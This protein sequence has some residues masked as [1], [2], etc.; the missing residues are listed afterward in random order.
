[1]RTT[2]L[3]AALLAMAASSARAEEHSYVLVG[4]GPG[5]STRPGWAARA[6]NL[7]VARKDG[8][9]FAWRAGLEAWADRVESGGGYSIGPALGVRAKNAFV[10]FGG[11]G[12]LF[13][14]AHDRDG[15]H[16]AW[17]VYGCASLGMFLDDEDD[18]GRRKPGRLL[19]LALRAERHFITG[20]RDTHMLSL[21]LSVGFEGS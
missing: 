1:V 9:F 21:V 14:F 7:F 2:I 4:A 20:A 15:M 10:T 17:T 13:G 6:Q 19:E 18:D 8:A 12:T 5:Y 16:G 11:G 3:T